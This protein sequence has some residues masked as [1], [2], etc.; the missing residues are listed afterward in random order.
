MCLG[1]KGLGLAMQESEFVC[2]ACLCRPM[3][4]RVLSLML[5]CLGRE[6]AVVVAALLHHAAWLC[7]SCAL[8]EQPRIAVVHGVICCAMIK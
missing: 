5:I 7:V 2:A 6:S 3:L 8:H 4:W 1:P